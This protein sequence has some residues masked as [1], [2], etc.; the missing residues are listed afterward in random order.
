MPLPAQCC[1]PVQAIVKGERLRIVIARPRRGRGALSAQREEVPLGCNLAVPSRI[2]GKLTVKSQLS[3]RDSHVTL[4]LGMTNLGALH[5]HWECLHICSCPRRNWCIP[6]ISGAS[7]LQVH[8][9]VKR[10]TV[11]RREPY[12]KEPYHEHCKLWSL[13]DCR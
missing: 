10:Y 5:V 11:W 12:R 6:L 3:P 1:Q 7:V 8:G 2:T 9:Q 13:S 4:L